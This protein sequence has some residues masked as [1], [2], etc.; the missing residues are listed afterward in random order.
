MSPLLPYIHRRYHC[1]AVDLPG[2]GQSPR[3]S[4]PI[5]MRWYADILAGLIEQVSRDKPIVVLGH[6]MGGLIALTMA[7]HHPD[8]VERMVLL[9]PTISGQLTTFINLFVAPITII[10]R[11]VVTG[12]LISLLE[13]NITWATDNIMRPA[14]LAARTDMSQEDYVKLK[15]DARQAGQGQVRS[16][17][18][19][20]MRR[21]DLRGKLGDIKQP[22]LVIWGLEDN[23]VPLKDA[24]VLADEIPKADM[25]FIPNVSHW[26][27]FEA[28]ELTQRYVEGFLGRPMSYLKVMSET[29][30]WKKPDDEDEDK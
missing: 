12:W 22:C 21:G 13:H 15:K 2:Y 26:P 4:Q 16:E 5:T 29:G 25:R 10:E 8:L 7:L 27:Q 23:T 11:H 20:A 28:A 18:F 19:W 3:P 1:L 6:S 14:S 30:I 24:G 9:S 17:C